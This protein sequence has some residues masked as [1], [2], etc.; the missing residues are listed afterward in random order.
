MFFDDVWV[1]SIFPLLRISF[2]AVGGVFGPLKRVSKFVQIASPGETLVRGTC[3]NCDHP[4]TRSRCRLNRSAS[5]TGMRDVFER[6]Y[7]TH[8]AL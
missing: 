2:T 3:A 5:S 1:L 8:S 6:K 4:W 7:E